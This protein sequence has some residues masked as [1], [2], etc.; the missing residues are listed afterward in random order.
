MFGVW[1]DAVDDRNLYVDIEVVMNNT[2]YYLPGSNANVFKVRREE[3]YDRNKHGSGKVTDIEM[4]AEEVFKLRQNQYLLLDR[5]QTEV[6]FLKGWSQLNTIGITAS[7]G[8]LQSLRCCYE[9]ME[10][11]IEK[12]NGE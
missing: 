3:N 6:E 7:S 9:R 1:A 12:V 11:V 2:V 8:L 5:L 10:F 4:T